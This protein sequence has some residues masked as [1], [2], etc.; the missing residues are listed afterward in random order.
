MA[1][2]EDMTE[3]RDRMGLAHGRPPNDLPESV[4]AA[5]TTTSLPLPTMAEPAIGEATLK[6]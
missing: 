1:T 2:T 4:N 5:G 3:A 6:G